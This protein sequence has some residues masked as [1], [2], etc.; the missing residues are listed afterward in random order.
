MGWAKGHQL[1]RGSGAFGL[2]QV[3]ARRVWDTHGD[4]WVTGWA[5]RFC[6]VLFV[7]SLS[8]SS[9]ALGAIMC[10]GFGTPYQ[11]I[12]LGCGVWKR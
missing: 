12:L 4:Q 10:I 6:I 5:M 8:A 3:L 9:E 7:I 2:G 11:G 1:G